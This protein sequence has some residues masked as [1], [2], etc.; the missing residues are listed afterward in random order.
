[1]FDIVTIPPCYMIMFTI[2]YSRSII[3]RL[4]LN[5]MNFDSKEGQIFLKSIFGKIFSTLLVTNPRIL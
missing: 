5:K 3:T 2:K 4:M 1:M